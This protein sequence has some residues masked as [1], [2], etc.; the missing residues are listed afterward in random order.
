MNPA[1]GVTAIIFASGV[2]LHVFVIGATIGAA[3]KI[4]ALP[5]SEIPHGASIPAALLVPH[6]PVNTYF[7]FIV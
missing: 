7:D 2:L 5:A 4:T 3:G 1:T 6:A